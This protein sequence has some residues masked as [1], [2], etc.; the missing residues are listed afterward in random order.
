MA[1]AL[2]S[3]V[4]FIPKKTFDEIFDLLP[5]PA[6]IDHA[7]KIDFHRAFDLLSPLQ[8]NVLIDCCCGYKRNEISTRLGITRR[9][10][11]RCL[12]E[13]RKQ[14]SLLLGEYL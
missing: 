3:P 4:V 6:G 9:Q 1:I 5:A 14:L 8:R 12:E 7:F 13:T 2:P 10:V 11:K